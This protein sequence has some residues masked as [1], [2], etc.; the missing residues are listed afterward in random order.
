MRHAMLRVRVRALT[1][2]AARAEAY[3]PLGQL[4]RVRHARLRRPSNLELRQ[5][6]R[7]R[8]RGAL[9][10]LVALVRCCCVDPLFLLRFLVRFL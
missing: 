10:P 6:P 2:L 4:A 9:E 1:E 7:A 5:P 3:V 8:L